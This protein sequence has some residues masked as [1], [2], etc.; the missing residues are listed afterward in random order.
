MSNKLK[1]VEDNYTKVV[2]AAQEKLK[3]LNSNNL[4]TQ[5][6]IGRIAR[7]LTDQPDKY[8]QKTLENLSAD[9]SATGSWEVKASY[10]RELRGFAARIDKA[11]LKILQDANAA[12]RNVIYLTRKHNSDELIE[13]VLARLA[14]NEITQLEICD[15]VDSITRELGVGDEDGDGDDDTGAGGGKDDPDPDRKE[16]SKVLKQVDGMGGVALEFMNKLKG[17]DEKIE[18]ICSESDEDAMRAAFVAFDEMCVTMTDL[19]KTWDAIVKGA[20]RS[21][22]KVKSVVGS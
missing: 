14:R 13:S 22:K 6:D 15:V 10:L 21:F 8:G 3:K 17:Y 16:L 18:H 9:L 11:G 12:I 7:D 2:Q 5:W 1:T 20:Q 4:A 19:N